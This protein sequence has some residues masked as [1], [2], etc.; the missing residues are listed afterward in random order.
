M[1]TVVVSLSDCDEVTGSDELC[2]SVVVSVEAEL[3]DLLTSVCDSLLP[4]Q[5]TRQQTDIINAAAR[6]IIL[7]FIVVSFIIINSMLIPV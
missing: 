2:E 3:S 5:D 7:F 6:D 4:P 1:V